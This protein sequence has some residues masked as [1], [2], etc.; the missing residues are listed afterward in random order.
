MSGDGV[1]VEQATEGLHV[2]PGALPG[3]AV[4][5][6]LLQVVHVDVDQL[7]TPE[8]AEVLDGGTVTAKGGLTGPGGWDTACRTAPCR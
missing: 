1:L 6:A 5:H 4:I 2:L 7:S 8:G 3:G